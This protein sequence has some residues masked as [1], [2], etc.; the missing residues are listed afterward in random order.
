[1]S[2]VAI[3]PTR[4]INPS[5]P[6]GHDLYLALQ[7]LRHEQ[8]RLRARNLAEQLSVSEGELLACR[9][10][11]SVYYKYLPTLF[12]CGCLCGWR[13]LCAWGWIMRLICW[14]SSAG[15]L[16]LPLLLR[17]RCLCALVCTAR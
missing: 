1:M 11:I 13:L 15:C 8:P 3:N 12:W 16:L 14:V 5:V 9:A 4:T 7:V 10:V 17:F 6:Q 2:Q